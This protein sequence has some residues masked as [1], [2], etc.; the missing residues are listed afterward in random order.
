MLYSTHLVGFISLAYHCHY[1]SSMRN[2]FALHSK[3]VLPH[4]LLHSAQVLPHWSTTRSACFMDVDCG[5][6]K[7]QDT[8]LISE[9]AFCVPRD[10]LQ[11]Y[12]PYTFFFF[13]K[14]ST[15]DPR[16]ENC[17]SFYKKSPPKIV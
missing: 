9:R 16:P 17:L 6:L 1:M 13:Q 4:W 15:F 5:D 11:L 8:G 2:H 10:L 14:Q 7:K 12:R 3:Q